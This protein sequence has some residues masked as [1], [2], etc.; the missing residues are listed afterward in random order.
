MRACEYVHNIGKPHV[1]DN[2]ELLLY[3]KILYIIAIPI[4]LLALLFAKA[5]NVPFFAC[6][7]SLKI[8]EGNDK[9]DENEL[10]NSRYS[11]FKLCNGPESLKKKK[12]NTLYTFQR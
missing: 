9:F 5:F 1:L 6:I 12:S 3:A 4:V 7:W 10:T 8:E 11:T 2:I